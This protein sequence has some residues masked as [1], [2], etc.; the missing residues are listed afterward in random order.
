VTNFFFRFLHS[1][2]P[3]H[4][5]PHHTSKA[6]QVITMSSKEKKSSSKSSKDEK[7]TDSPKVNK[8][9][10]KTKDKEEP[11]KGEKDAKSKDKA[12]P[13]KKE[14]SEEEDTSEE[15]GTS[16]EEE[17]GDTKKKEDPK[18]KD[19]EKDKGEKDKGEKDKGEKDKGEKDK[20]EK[21]KKG[22]GKA[23][24]EEEE[25]EDE[26]DAAKHAFD[27]ASSVYVHSNQ[28]INVYEKRNVHVDDDKT[29]VLR[30]LP[31]TLV[32]SSLHFRSVTDNKA[33]LAD[34][35]FLHGAQSIT[36]LLNENRNNPVSIRLRDSNAPIQGRVVDV[37][38]DE[39]TL[40][41][42]AEETTVLIRKD[43]IVAVE[44]SNKEVD[45]APTL[46]GVVDTEQPG[47]HKAE[48]Y[49]NASGI[50]WSTDYKLVL[51]SDDEVELSGW[52]SI[53]NTTGKAFNQAALTL[54]A[55]EIPEAAPADKKGF[56][57]SS[58]SKASKA[59]S[60][61]S[62]GALPSLDLSSPRQQAAAARHFPYR[63]DRPVNLPPHE[64]KQVRL[65][66]GKFAV[67]TVYRCGFTRPF[68][69]Y[70]PTWTPN[71]PAPILRVVL[72]KN[73]SKVDFPA[74]HLD[75]L[76]RDGS[77]LKVVHQQDLPRAGAAATIVFP[78]SLKSN[79]VADRKSD[80]KHDQKKHL[81]TENVQ[82]DIRNKGTKAENVYVEEYLY[83]WNQFQGL[84]SSPKHELNK[85]DQLLTWTV[86][87]E[88]NAVETIKYQVQYTNV[89]GF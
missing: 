83:R 64:T 5:P 28:S 68:S 77:F 52:Y 88:P 8:K 29:V 19:T 89:P 18:K 71:S 17:K 6:T 45:V 80:V 47:D 59:A 43:A 69:T 87:V 62:S 36:D 84:Q 70:E 2:L 32:P 13:P 25:E 73:K 9:D 58:V 16:E 1:A 74:G 37:S 44:V 34:Y 4:Q 50:S 7:A 14:E 23:A 57:A 54:V 82:I 3:T 53:Q 24:A 72:L 76:R 41:R 66:S 30:D 78:L 79:L 49:Y 81:L 67:R 38:Q 60:Q 63:V 20:G 15:E 40:H 27:A 56:L 86:K 75:V 46:R 42:E 85:E 51:L 61:V 22:K 33:T 35:I 48:L 55:T 39:V 21:D 11:K 10:E 26:E 31:A 12:K 65:I